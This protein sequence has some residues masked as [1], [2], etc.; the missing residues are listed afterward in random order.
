MKPSLA[1]I[2]AAL[3]VLTTAPAWAVNKCTGPD[4]KIVFQDALCDVTSK[5]AEP[6]KIWDSRL[7]D[8]G[9]KVSI[10]MSEEEVLRAWGA[11]DSVNKTISTSGVRKQLVYGRGLRNQQYLYIENGVLRTIQ[12][13]N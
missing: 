11:P 10:G 12:S 1:A 3:L 6:V 7:V 4:G 8:G 9:G 2:T 13:S 5:K